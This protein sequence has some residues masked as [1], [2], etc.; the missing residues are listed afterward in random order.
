M[1][2]LHCPR[3]AGLAVAIVSAFVLLGWTLDIPW[4]MAIVAPNTAFNV[5]LA[6]AC[7]LLVG[8][9]RAAPACSAATASAA[10]WPAACSRP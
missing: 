6:G 4:L 1:D 5:R 7:L 10:S 9:P 8:R 3:V 2:T